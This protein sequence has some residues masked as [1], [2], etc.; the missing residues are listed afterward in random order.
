VSDPLREAAARLNAAGVSN[1]RLDARLLWEHAKSFNPP[2]EG[3]SNLAKPNSG[4]DSS[5][6]ATR[7]PSP[8]SP[9]APLAKIST[10][11]QG[12]G[13]VAERFQ[14]LITRRVAREPLAYIVG[15]KEFW[16]LEFEVGPG[17][18]I[19]RSESE[20]LIEQALAFFPDRRAALSVLDLGTGTGCL[21]VAFLKEFLN[22]RGVGIEKS[23]KARA[24]AQR[25][26]AR[27]DLAARCEIR[28][29][30]WTEMTAGCFD[31][32]LANPPYIR[33]A[34]LAGL[35]PE[36]RFEPQEALDGGPDGLAAYRPLAPLVARLL[37]P[38]GRAFLEIGP[39]DDVIALLAAAGLN[40]VRVHHDLA[41]IP[42]VLSAGCGDFPE[43]TVGKPEGKG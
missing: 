13:E 28:A 25:N 36:L 26:L 38:G 8:K 9:L 2:L 4:R 31:A 22:A 1:P 43:K 32:I 34:D 5:R 12:E 29:G 37:K 10:L 7:N 6:N 3:G 41:G 17:V 18:L 11:P 42:R 23:E 14:S 27:Y 33:T 40:F 21:L 30:D 39:A 16:S 35:E 20:T 19:P 15:R 24:Y